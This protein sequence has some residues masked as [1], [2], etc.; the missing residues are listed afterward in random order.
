MHYVEE[1]QVDVIDYKVTF[2]YTPATLGSFDEPPEA[3]YYE[4]I[5]FERRTPMENLTAKDIKELLEYENSQEF[6]DALIEEIEELAKWKKKYF[7]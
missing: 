6:N 5:S 7:Y 4:I 3:E 2:E 1:V